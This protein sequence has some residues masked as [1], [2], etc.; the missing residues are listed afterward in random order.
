MSLRLML[1]HVY[2]PAME[3]RK[4]IT[5]HMSKFIGHIKTSVLQAYGNVSITVPEIPEGMSDEEVKANPAL[6]KVL[7]DAVVSPSTHK[8]NPA[9]CVDRMDDQ[10]P[11]PRRGGGQARGRPRSPH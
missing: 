1:Q 10:D 8:A 6:M 5:H 2:I 9:L 11:R 7:N 4:E 3:S